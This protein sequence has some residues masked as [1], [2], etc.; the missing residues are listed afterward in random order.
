MIP[1]WLLQQMQGGMGGQSQAPMSAGSGMPPTNAP[2]SRPTQMP[3]P[4]VAQSP[5]M[6]SPQQG[7]G[8][9]SPMNPAQMGMLSQMLKSQTAQPQASQATNN[10]ITAATGGMVPPQVAALAQGQ[11]GGAGPSAGILS[12]LFPGVF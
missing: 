4:G 2:M 10:A 1:P 12:M 7:Q 11:G 6:A 8:G 3:T 9:Q 5:P